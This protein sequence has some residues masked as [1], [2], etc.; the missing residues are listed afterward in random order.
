M[1][2]GIVKIICVMCIMIF[3][4]MVTGGDAIVVNAANISPV[5]R[6]YNVNTGEHFYTASETEYKA[7]Q[8]VGWNDEG[9]G[10]YVEPGVGNPVYRVYNPNAKGGDHYYTMSKGEAEILVNLGWKW[11]NDGMP[12]FYSNGKVPLYVEYNPNA[13]SGAHNYTTSLSENN[14]LLDIGWQEGNVAWYVAQSG[15]SYVAK[16]YADKDV[17]GYGGNETAITGSY[18]WIYSDRSFDPADFSQEVPAIEFSADVCLSGNTDDYGMQF[19]IA[20]TADADGQIGV[21]L[22]YQAGNDS[23][24]GQGRINVSTINF[25]SDAGIY[26]SQYYA[27]NTSA[28]YIT[29]GN[30]VHVTVKYYESGYM[31]TYVNDYLCGQFI[32]SLDHHPEFI[33]HFNSN[34]TCTVSNISVIKKGEDISFDKTRANLPFENK[35]YDISNNGVA[36]AIY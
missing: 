29:P 36:A 2:S 16:A 10:W 3:V 8:R 5:F 31:Q 33:L 1:K 12:A 6:L 13:E 21:D 25:P 22:H 32:T 11:D 28:P 7:L 14:Y 20:G 23:R 18:R 35:T 9:V 34:A 15:T 17:T 19:V 27:V 30:V 4:N 24:F 26:G